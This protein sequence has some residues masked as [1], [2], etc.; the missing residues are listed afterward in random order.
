[1]KKVLKNKATRGNQ[2]VE[3][4][5]VTPTPKAIQ[6]AQ[7]VHNQAFREAVVGKAILKQALVKH[8]RE[9]GLW[10]DD[11]ETEYQKLT[12]VILDGEKSL[13]RGKIKL[14]E[15]KAIAFSMQDAR[16]KML[17][18]LAERRELEAHTAE[19][20][21]DNTRFN[22]L[23]SACTVY[24]DTGKPVFTSLDDYMAKSTEDYAWEAART[25]AQMIH[26]YDPETEKK[27]PENA[28]LIKYK[29]MNED[30]RLVDKDGNLIDRDGRR[31]DAEGRF[32]ND[33]GL[34][35][36]REGNRVDEDGN[37]V[38]DDAGAFLDDDGNPIEEVVDAAV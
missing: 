21:A 31:I 27:L 22:Y 8:M 26:G 17:T 9:Q 12:K 14:A 34:H 23:V 5:V 32:V 15:A 18:L 20:H 37:Y 16:Q 4:A 7:I 2:Q 33:E 1:M 13:K 24:N 38:F 30:M 11:K 10:D 28:F 29:F 6:E 19:A 25:L 3:L 36:D 35:V